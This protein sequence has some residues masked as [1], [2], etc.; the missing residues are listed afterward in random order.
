MKP[1]IRVLLYLLCA[2]QAVFGIAFSLQLPFAVQLWPLPYTNDTAF[3]FIGSVFLAAACATTWCLVSREDGALF[4]IGLDYVMIFIPVSIFAFQLAAAASPAQQGK[5][6]LFGITGIIQIILGSAFMW[7][8]RRSPI[9]DQRPTPRL[10]RWSFVVFVIALLIVGIQMVLKVP[11]ILPWSMTATSSVLYGWIFIG[12][13][14]YFAYGVL[15]PRWHNAAGQLFGFVGYDI[16]LLLPFLAKLPTIEPER[17]ASLIAYLV[18]LIYTT[19]LAGYYLFVN[20]G[21]RVW[22]QQASQTV[23]GLQSEPV[24]DGIQPVNSR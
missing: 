19:L 6:I 7:W 8:A 24:I 21:T 22:G 4:G 3:L 2:G 20:Q 13:S 1:Y 23:K 9:R 14:W 11:D 12:A 17:R 5:L 15:R 16:V 10:V 18:V